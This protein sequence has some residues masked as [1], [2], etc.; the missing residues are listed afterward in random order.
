[1]KVSS[2]TV[3][4]TGS[5]GECGAAGSLEADLDVETAPLEPNPRALTGVMNVG[6]SGRV[7]KVRC[8][9][10]GLEECVAHGG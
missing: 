5:C 1:M 3:Q 4:L 9:S 2:Q 6:L 8:R 10:C 7:T